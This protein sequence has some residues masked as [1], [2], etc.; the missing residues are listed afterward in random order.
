MP[1]SIPPAEQRGPVGRSSFPFALPKGLAQL[2][3]LPRWVGWRWTQKPNGEWDKPL[4]RADYPEFNA[5]TLKHKTWCLLDV[6]ERALIAGHLDGIGY[7]VKDDHDHVF[8]D[9]DKCRDPETGDIADWATEFVEECNSYTEITPS[10]RGLRVI[11]THGGFLKAQIHAG[12]KLPGG[13]TG[14]IYFRATRYVTV[15]GHHLAGTPETLNDISG[16]VLDLLARAGKRLEAERPDVAPKLREEAMAPI[17]D[18]AAALKV[19]RN[20]DLPY[21]DWVRIGL[22]SYA[23]SGGSGEGFEAWMRWSAKSQKH[24]DHECLR[25]WHSFAKAPPRNISFGSL[26]YLARAA[27]PFFVAPSWR[28]ERVHDEPPHDPETGEIFGDDLPKARGKLNSRALRFVSIAELEAMPLPEWLIHGVVPS[29]GLVV[30]YGPPKSGKT[31]IVLSMA[32]HIAA[33]RDWFGRKVKQGAVVYIIGEGLGGFSMRLKAMR[34]RYDLPQDLPFYAVP[35]AVNFRD[36]ADMDALEALIR[37]HIPPGVRIALVVV[38]TLARA[39]VGVE[40]NSAKEVG[41]V[42]AKCEAIGQFL[43]CA[44]M[45]V[46]HTG[47]DVER[48]IRGTNAITG[49]VEASF[50]IQAAGPEHVR[51]TNDN[52]KDDGKGAP[53]LFR[54]EQINLGLRTSLVPVLE[55]GRGPG[56]PKD[57]DAPAPE[58]LLKL[59]VISMG[60]SRELPF[61][62][63]AESMGLTNRGRQDLAGLIPVGRE[64]AI[65]V[66][67]GS[68]FAL[69]WRRIA[70]E[71]KTAP[72][73]VHMELASD[74][75]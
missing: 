62:R 5:S 29:E 75:E 74:A 33:G 36:E 56:R 57:P 27:N 32:L 63:V 53:L 50:L 34:Q 2:R 72:I 67:L 43:A 13:G 39:M 23:A 14:E 18:I 44:V 11:G 71:H 24:M 46:A 25:V 68:S 38:D 20:D 3:M 8:A 6:A 48:G 69:L 47:K 15:S 51:M 58:E 52:Q 73:F 9:L 61:A 40:E 22:A 54:M 66:A 26:Y 42:I 31:F 49:A 60:A 7:V 1:D 65:R 21:D 64:Y 4:F 12:Y 45:P 59:V 28:G 55:E 37:E 16:P 30:P 17:A 19:I 41:E 10:G 35:R 70:G